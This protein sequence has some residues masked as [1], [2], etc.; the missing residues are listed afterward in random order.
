MSSKPSFTFENGV[1]REIERRREGSMIGVLVDTSTWFV[2]KAWV[3]DDPLESHNQEM[4]RFRSCRSS[5]L[6][7]ISAL[8]YGELPVEEV[9]KVITDKKCLKEFCSKYGLFVGINVSEGI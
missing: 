3:S 8:I 9:N 2:V 5:T 4:E 7:T 6:H 1:Y